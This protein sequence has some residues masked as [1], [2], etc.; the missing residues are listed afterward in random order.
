[1]AEL[2]VA[3]YVPEN[4]R[5][6]FENSIDLVTHLIWAHLFG[7]TRTIL[8]VITNFATSASEVLTETESKPLKR[9]RVSRR[10]P[11]PYIMLYQLLLPLS[12]WEGVFDP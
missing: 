7:G 9:C 1:M 2:L 10:I 12:A 5:R 8:E 4:Q 6:V 3:F 11:C